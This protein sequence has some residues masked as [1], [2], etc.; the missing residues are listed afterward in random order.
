[1]RGKVEGSL[2]G[3]SRRIAKSIHEAGRCLIVQPAEIALLKSI[4]D[5]QLRQFAAQNG[6]IVVHHLG[7][8]Q[9]EFFKA[10]PGQ[11]T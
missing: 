8:E 6:W 3:L 9:I 2:E 11:L 7:G 5:E 10:A 4:G 1:M